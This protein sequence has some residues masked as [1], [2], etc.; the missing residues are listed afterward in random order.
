MQDYIEGDLMEVY[1]SR[2]DRSGKL[3]ADL[4]FIVDVLLLFR[5]GIIKPTEASNKLI[6]Y[7]MLTNYLKVGFRNILRYKVY[8]SINISG[9]AVGIASSILIMLNVIDELSY[10]RFHKDSDRIY[11]IGSSGSFEGSEFHQA[12]SSSPIAEAMLQEIPEVTS[13]VRFYWWRSLPM[14]FNDKSFIEKKALVA[15]SNFFQFFSFPL[16]SGNPNTALNGTDKVV[17]TEAT[18]KRF[19]GEDDPMGKILLRGEGRVAT[20]ITGVARDLPFNSHL[21]FDMIF[22]GESYQY[23]QN[24]H[25]SNTYLHTYIKTNEFSDLAGVKKKLDV[26]TEKNIGPEL[27]EITGLSVEQFRAS[28]NRFGF[29]LQ[30][31]LDIHLKSDLGE[32]I[33]QGNIQYVYVFGAVAFFILLIACINFMNLSTARY[34]TRAKEVGVRKSVGAARKLLISQFLSESMIYSFIATIFAMAIVGLALQPFNE[35]AGKNIELNVFKTPLVIIGIISF[36]L[37]TGFIAGSYPAFYLT[38]FNPVN[39][40]KGKVQ[41]GFRN[42]KLRNSLVIFQFVTS[43]VLILGSLVVY[44]QLKYMQEKNM[45]FN[46]ENVIDVSN[47]WSLGNSSEEFK[48]ELSQYPEFKSVSFS[49]GLPPHIADGNLFRKGGTEQDIVLNVITVD[50]DQIAVMGFEMSLGRF[51]SIDFPSDS[52]AIVLNE[53]AYK[54]L[55]FDRIEGNS[56]INYNAE[57]PTPFHLIGVIKDFNFENLRSSVKPMAMLLSVGKNNFMV[58]QANNDI[59]IRIASGDAT[60][61]IDKLEN[62]W[63]KFSSSPF[64]FTFLDQNID[65]MFRSEKRMGKII[66][67]FSTL[68]IF[69]ACLGLFGLAAYLGEQRGKELGIRKVLGAS[70]SQLVVLLIKDFTWPIGVAFVIAAPFGWYIMS[71]WL[72]EFAYHVD[73]EFWMVI[74]AGLL[75][76]LIA[77]LTISVESMKVATGNPIKALKSE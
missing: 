59:A 53:T 67:I 72:Q 19:F 74:A 11:R 46:K 77:I 27:E 22:S 18:A 12:A 70:V 26:I 38:S 30:P 44:K 33:P 10:D 35:L 8:S 28:G 16:I 54:Q 69:I 64:E 51:F 3:K 23:M 14:R 57:N 61:S 55:G 1:E 50:Y 37:I 15:D 75:S 39:V 66:F 20:E 6:N 32:I 36:G 42:S 24:T 9:L 25:W 5:P 17:I 4:R 47:G 40:L 31:L 68:T 2:K 45:G 56:M 21:Q 63:K 7:S 49:S 41:E 52:T 71:Q 60:A 76:L 34:A 13:A 58:R 62:I 29:F 48:N 43:I 73:V 65:A